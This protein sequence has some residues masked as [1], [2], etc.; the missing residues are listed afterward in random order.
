MA[1][2][3]IGFFVLLAIAVP[4]YYLVRKKYQW[5]IL[6]IASLVFYAFA[7][8]ASAGFIL[9][10]ALSTFF[11]GKMLA[12]YTK[13]QKKVRRRIVLLVLLVNFGML[14]VVK[15]ANFIG[16]SVNAITSLLSGGHIVPVMNIL[17]PL[18]ISFYIF[19][20]ISY[21]ID[22]YRGKCSPER[23]FAKYL[24]FVSLFPQLVQGPISKFNE[25]SAE[26][27]TERSFDYEH[28]KRG[29]QLMLFGFLKKLIIADR[30]AILVDHVFKSYSN[31]GG[32]VIFFT[33]FIYSVQL[34]CDFSGGID[35]AR[36]CAGLFGIE[37]TENFRQPFFAISIDDYW[38]RWHISLSRWMKDYLFYPLSLSKAFTRLGRK[39]RRWFKGYVG[40]V[41]PT[42]IA[43]FVVFLAV[44]AWQG[45][46]WKFIAYGIWN[47]ALISLGILFKPLTTAIRKKTG[48]TDGSVLMT[49]FGIARTIL[50]ITIGRYFSRAAGFRAALDMLRH[51][52]RVIAPA[53][54]FNGTILTLGLNIYDWILVLCALAVVFVVGLIR[55][56]GKSAGQELDKK[57]VIVQFAV[58]FS[59]VC[60][61]II[62]GIFSQGY[63]A[64]EFIYRQV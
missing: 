57:P 38:R 29:I 3:S 10:T 19:Q 18:G 12:K 54:L 1:F 63:I 17:L 39:T 32:A 49:A 44:G 51:T 27:I 52:V 2:N 15:Y 45:G 6:L 41:L 20:S 26:L 25:L 5:I 46:S 23:N 53:E 37:L 22:I 60:V 36:G 11:A 62:W 64:S 35:V 34:Y 31:Y 30:F 40:K 8:L 42:C 55:E 58:V 61:L 33:V 24:L 28:I 14:I 48:A 21:V 16:G 13:E 9:V 56:R 50:L 7:G 43:T 59:I 4:A 47:G